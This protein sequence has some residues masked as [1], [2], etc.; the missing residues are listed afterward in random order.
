MQAQ[1]FAV[2]SGN[3]YTDQSSH[4][5]SQ[6]NRTNW[7][8]GKLDM[9]TISGLSQDLLNY[10]DNNYPASVSKP[11]KAFQGVNANPSANWKIK[12]NDFQRLPLIQKLVD[13]FE[14][15]FPHLA[16]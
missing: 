9:H 13:H 12:K 8:T 7:V 16:I 11:C 2:L 15:L 4:S 10:W 1:L 14:T 6:G 3:E 5:L